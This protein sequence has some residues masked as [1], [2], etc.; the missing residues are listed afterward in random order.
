MLRVL[1]AV[2]GLS[3]AVT[4]RGCSSLLCP[5]FLWLSRVGAPPRCCARASDSAASVVA[6][7]RL[8]GCTG[9]VAPRHVGSSR[10]TDRTCV[11]CIGRLTLIHYA[12]RE[13]HPLPL[14]FA[15]HSAFPV[16]CFV[17]PALSSP[18][19]AHNLE[20][21]HFPSLSLS[22]FMGEMRMVGSAWEAPSGISASVR[23][24]GHTCPEGPVPL[25]S[26]VGRGGPQGLRRG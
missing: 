20:Q 26:G 22:L 6:E 25:T 16:L 24:A 21:R 2:P 23:R 8:F 11:P 13:V 10:N 1:V 9:L 15:L 18:S 4:S 3:L 5:G 14:L 12:T 17:R 19:P 7:L